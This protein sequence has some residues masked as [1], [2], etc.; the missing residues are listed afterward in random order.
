MKLFKSYNL[1]S[2][3]GLWLLKVCHRTLLD[4]CY[5]TGDPTVPVSFGANIT[6][7]RATPVFISVPLW[8][9]TVYIT[10]LETDKEDWRVHD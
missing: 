4:V 3:K 9:L 5:D 8:K 10:L 1:G 2:T 6:F 7:D